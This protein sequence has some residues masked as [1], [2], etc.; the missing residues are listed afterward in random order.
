M[1]LTLSRVLLTVILFAWPLTIMGQLGGK[2]ITLKSAQEVHILKKGVFLR[3]YAHDGERLAV[4][5]LRRVHSTSLVVGSFIRSDEIN[6]GQI[7]KITISGRARIHHNG[8]KYARIGGAIGL[9]VGLG[10]TAWEIWFYR[11]KD[12]FLG[13]EF[14][15]VIYTTLCGWGGAIPGYVFGL[16]KGIQ[17]QYDDLEFIIGAG[18][19]VIQITE[20]KDNN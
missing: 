3:I 7:G 9:V 11:G 4:G 15:L 2:S 18:E 16:G 12:R 1:K 5:L 14:A 10:A 13:P 19:W 17:S 6:Y 20:H 8:K